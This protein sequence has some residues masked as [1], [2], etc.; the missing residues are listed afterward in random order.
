MA[1]RP[2]NRSAISSAFDLRYASKMR[3][4]TGTHKTTVIGHRKKLK[5]SSAHAGDSSSLVI[6]IGHS[7]TILSLML[8]RQHCIS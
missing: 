5:N 6:I 4:R 7:P 3:T 2:R 1:K 8:Q